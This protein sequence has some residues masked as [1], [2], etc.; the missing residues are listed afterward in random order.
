[1]GDDAVDG[2]EQAEGDEEPVFNVTLCCAIRA[3][4]E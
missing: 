3:T 2:E 4:S 1:V